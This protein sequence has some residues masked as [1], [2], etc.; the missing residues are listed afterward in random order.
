MV[1]LHQIL[2][3]SLAALQDRGI[4]PGPE[5]PETGR[6][7][8]VH[9]ASHQRIVHADD[10]QVNRLFLRKFHDFI[11]FHSANGH[12]FRDLSDPRIARCAVDLIHSGALRH[13]GCDRVFSA[14][15]SY[16]QNFHSSI[17]PFCLC[18][19]C[20]LYLS[21]RH[22]HSAIGDQINT[23]WKDHPF[24]LLHDPP[25]QDFRCIARPD[26]HRLL[27]DDRPC[28]RTFI[29]EMHRSAGDPDSPGQRRL[30]DFNSIIAGAAEGRDQRRMDIDDPVLI[31]SD[32]LRRYDY[33]ES[34]QHDKIRR[35]LLCL[36]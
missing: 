22:R 19:F 15:A 34:R 10:G 11:K 30:M 2:G 28:I 7:H 24:C 16:D 12:A 4:L 31:T 35:R 21:V 6:F 1:F 13:T 9:Q 3:E 36:L 29:H 14:A 23:P 5:Y 26:F 25:L 20:D 33:Q 27:H 18:I 32:Q 8:L 17:L